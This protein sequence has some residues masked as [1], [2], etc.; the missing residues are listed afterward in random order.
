MRKLN[1]ILGVLA[2][3]GLLLIT[4]S[5]DSEKVLAASEIPSEINAFVGTHFPNNNI[6]Q[7]IEDRDGL[8]KTYDVILSDNITL[9]FTGKREIKDI[10]SNSKL[11]DSVIPTQ[12][13]SYVSENFPDNV[14][15]D[16]ELDG[17]NQQ[18]GLD[19]GMDLKFTMDGQFLRIDD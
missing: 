15:T 5:C 9:E 3:I 17:N 7:A 16:W 8:S 1:S 11:P 4:V 13:S 18:V 6:V 10:D 2:L 12:I 14:I 19:N